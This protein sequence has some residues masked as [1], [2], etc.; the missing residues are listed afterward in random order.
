M[1]KYNAA[2]R[3][4]SKL[5]F[6]ED[7]SFLSGFV[8]N[9]KLQGAKEYRKIEAEQ[10]LSQELRFIPYEAQKIQ[11]AFPFEQEKYRSII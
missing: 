3:L 7:L 4:N 8:A 5:N 10:V 9:A 1:A 11:S 6:E 2:L